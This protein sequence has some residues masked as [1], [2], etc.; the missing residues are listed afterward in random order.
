MSNKVKIAVDAMSGD[1]APKK[2]KILVTG[3]GS[4]QVR[5]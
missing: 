3:A 4:Q 5:E 2:I 1:N